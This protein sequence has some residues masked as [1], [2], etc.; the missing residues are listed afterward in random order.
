MEYGTV[1]AGT[2]EHAQQVADLIKC[3]AVVDFIK[4]AGRNYNKPRA[5]DDCGEFYRAPDDG[6]QGAPGGYF[7]NTPGWCFCTACGHRRLKKAFGIPVNYMTAQPA[8]FSEY[9]A[10]DWQRFMDRGQVVTGPIGTGKTHFLYAL[11]NEHL[12]TGER[13]LR[14]VDYHTMTR[15]MRAAYK[16]PAYRSEEQIVQEFARPVALFIDDV[17]G[18]KREE[19]PSED[20]DHVLYEVVRE[21][22]VLRRKTYISSNCNLDQLKGLGFNPRTISRLNERCDMVSL[23]GADRRGA[24]PGAP[25]VSVF[26][27]SEAARAA[28]V[29]D[30]TEA[31]P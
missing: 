23:T 7:G 12:R 29:E 14:F 21:R 3:P 30:P 1:E 2:L 20:E 17:F 27:P 22:Y 15:S 4:V 9:T 25:G 19:K 26:E 10:A 28:Y 16:P 13:R 6:F 18:S 8:D 11:L 24:Q 5:C 31:Q